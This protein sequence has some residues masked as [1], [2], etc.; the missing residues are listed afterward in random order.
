[1]ERI[2]PTEGRLFQFPAR[3]LAIVRERVATAAER[4]AIANVGDLLAEQE[5]SANFKTVA[6]V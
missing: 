2:V 6:A 3:R 4:V 5:T 1:M